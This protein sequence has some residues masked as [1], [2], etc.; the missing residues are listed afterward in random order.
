MNWRAAS[1]FRFS[2]KVYRDVRIVGRVNARRA[3][4]A[5]CLRTHEEGK[6]R[7]NHP[8]GERGILDPG[9]SIEGIL[10]AYTMHQEIPK[11]YFHDWSVPAQLSIID[12]FGRRHVS[13]IDISVD[14]TANIIRPG[15]LMQ[16]PRKG[17]F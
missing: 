10:L 6:D 13:F 4:C 9:K 3:R 2:A 7:P 17:L 15:M 11:Y 5:L 8:V 1:R 12:Q 16:R 14:R